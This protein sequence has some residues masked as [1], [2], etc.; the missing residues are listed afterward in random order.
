MRYSVQP[1][2]NLPSSAREE[3]AAS[4]CFPVSSA[5]SS[6]PFPVSFPFAPMAL[7]AEEGHTEQK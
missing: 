6:Q 1:G 3:A 4:P 2:F 7:F 5:V